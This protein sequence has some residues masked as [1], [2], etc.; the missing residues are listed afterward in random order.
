M[1]FG[2]ILGGTGLI[3]VAV[4]QKFG[5]IDWK[6][7]EFGLIV[8]DIGQTLGVVDQKF[9]DI[10]SKFVGFDSTLVVFGLILVVVDRRFEGTGRRQCCLRK[11]RRCW[12]YH[13][14][15]CRRL[16]VELVQSFGLALDERP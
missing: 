7:A 13:S 6:F 8:G 12:S 3:V 10:G 11:I 16:V 1:E 15:C 2:W 14:R 5:D 4:D 9:G